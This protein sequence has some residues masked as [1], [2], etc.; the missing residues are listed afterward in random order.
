MVSNNPTFLR[1][2]TDEQR[3]SSIVLKI[4]YNIFLDI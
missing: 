2:S 3:V 1:I 4:E